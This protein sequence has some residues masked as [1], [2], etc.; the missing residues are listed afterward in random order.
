MSPQL[1]LKPNHSSCLPFCTLSLDSKVEVASGL[2]Q[3]KVF[4]KRGLDFRNPCSFI[5][6]IPEVLW[7]W[8]DL[9]K[10]CPCEA[11]RSGSHL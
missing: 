8:G 11:G 1:V 4:E 5:P 10:K 7:V 6:R 3:V 2:V 9:L